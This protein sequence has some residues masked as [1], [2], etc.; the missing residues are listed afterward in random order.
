M[1]SVHGSIAITACLLGL[2]YAGSASAQEAPASPATTPPPSSAGSAS[3]QFSLATPPSANAGSASAQQA[4]PV[5]P[6]PTPPSPGDGPWPQL[7]GHIGHAL[8]IAHLGGPRSTHIGF[9]HNRNSFFTLAPVFGITLKLTKRLAFDFENIVGLNLN[10]GSTINNGSAISY[11]VD[12]GIVYDLGPVAVGGRVGFTVTDPRANIS[13]IPLI[14]KSF[15]IGNMIRGFGDNL[16]VFIEGDFPLLI[17]G[18]YVNFSPVVHA[19]FSF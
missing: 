19:G 6:A 18:G 13:L 9:G 8:P 2:A 5:S 7:G 15:K 10:R 4:P 14:N 12:P 17:E 3:A 11:T 16:A 1:D